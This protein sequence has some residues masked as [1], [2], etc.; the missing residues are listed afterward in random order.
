M[1]KTKKYKRVPAVDKSVDILELLTKMKKPLTNQEIA[2]SL[3]YHASTTYHLINTLVDRGILEAHDERKYFLGIKLYAFGM[4]SVK[5]SKNL[6]S[7]IHPFLEEINRKT[8]LS[9]FFGVSSNE[10]I[11]VLDKIDSLG[12]VNVTREVGESISI[13]AGAVSRAFLSQLSDTEVDKY[14]SKVK[15]EKITPYTCTNKTKLKEII[16][17]VRKD[18]FAIDDQERMLGLRAIAIPLNLKGIEAHFV[19]WA[20]G[21]IGQLEEKMY[22][23]YSIILKDI[24]DKV[25]KVAINFS[26]KSPTSFWWDAIE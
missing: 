14:L 25:E 16:K 23:E 3:N 9:V 5:Y 2:S 1:L 19:I 11:I 21:L 22:S 20:L 7:T 24:R 4:A 15:L 6:I 12:G 17:Q 10:S 8:N 18:G 13:W 26:Y